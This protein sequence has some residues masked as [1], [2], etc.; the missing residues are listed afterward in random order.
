MKVKAKFKCNSVTENEYNKQVSL[1]AIY[2][3]EGENAD[4]A[5]ATPWGE[6]KMNIDKDTPA[7][8]F[9]K[10]GKSYYLFFEETE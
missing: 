3:T 7:A 10:P 8:D 6:H 5:K 2:G 9:F 4:F 1:T